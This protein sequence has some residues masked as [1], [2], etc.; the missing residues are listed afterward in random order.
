MKIKAIVILLATLTLLALPAWAETGW[1][2]FNS[3][4]F[5]FSIDYPADWDS[6]LSEDA[7]L[8]ITK[9]DVDLPLMIAVAAE[10][11]GVDEKG[12]AVIPDMEETMSALEESISALGLGEAVIIE[13]GHG[14]VNSLPAY[15]L[16]LTLSYMGLLEMRM[17]NA[18]IDMGSSTVYLVISGENSSYKNN[19]DIFD[20]VKISLRPSI[21]E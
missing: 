15:I 20:R 16:D 9:L 14:E 12:K 5:G 18:F 19:A 6:Q 11:N 17:Y 10:A 21:A 2:T 8:A 7:L 3:A 13:R 4:E 1:K